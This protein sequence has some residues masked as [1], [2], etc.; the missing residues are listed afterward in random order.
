M[1]FYLSAAFEVFHLFPS[2]KH[3]LSILIRHI[4][5]FDS[6]SGVPNGDS[7]HEN[8]EGAPRG[9]R[10]FNNRA[11]PRRSAQNSE[12]GGKPAQVEKVNNFDQ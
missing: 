5:D 10:R 2:Q 9:R 6:Y 3:I 11:G 12:S 8:Q 7:N 1:D 4:L